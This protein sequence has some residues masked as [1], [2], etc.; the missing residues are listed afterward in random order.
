MNNAIKQV[1]WQE[2]IDFYQNYQQW[3]ADDYPQWIET[4]K[5]LQVLTQLYREYEELM[6]TLRRIGAPP[7][8]YQIKTSSFVPK[9]KPERREAH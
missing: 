6:S 1:P 2:W 9:Q 8:Q 4:N 5:E 3:V 7:Y